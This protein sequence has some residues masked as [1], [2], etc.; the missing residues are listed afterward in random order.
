MVE[1]AK[2]IL[3][4]ARN[5]IR[6]GSE[7]VLSQMR[8]NL[9]N[10]KLKRRD[11]TKNLLEG[12]KGKAVVHEKEEKVKE[13]LEEL[14]EKENMLAHKEEEIKKTLSDLEKKIEKLHQVYSDLETIWR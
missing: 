13:Q 4:T 8:E 12:Q 7:D 9:E 10:L 3:E 5:N 2:L 1:E 14:K 6:E 11:L